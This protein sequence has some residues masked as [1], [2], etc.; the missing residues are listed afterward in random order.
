MSNRT[1]SGAST[2]RASC[3]VDNFGYHYD[4]ANVTSEGE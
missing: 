1:E 2:S 3:T 4:I